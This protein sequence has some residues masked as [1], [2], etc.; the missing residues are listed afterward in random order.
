MYVLGR[1]N[2]DPPIISTTQG[3]VAALQIL[4]DNLNELDSSSLFNASNIA[5]T[6]G[7]AAI[8]TLGSNI[9]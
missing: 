8:E 1:T 9:V 2:P 3:Y 5:T 4:A 7:E 6:I